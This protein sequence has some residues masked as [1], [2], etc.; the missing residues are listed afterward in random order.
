MIL[1]DGGGMG[2]CCSG[3]LFQKD[4]LMLF[5]TFE[6]LMGF[7]CLRILALGGLS[8]SVLIILQNEEFLFVLAMQEEQGICS[9]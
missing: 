1:C 9:T 6:I 8:L 2:D 4:S 7:G 5:R 3:K